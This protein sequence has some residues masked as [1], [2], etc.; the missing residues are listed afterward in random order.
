MS[1]RPFFNRKRGGFKE[2]VS[3]LKLG[4]ECTFFPGFHWEFA[5]SIG[6]CS[7][8]SVAVIATHQDGTEGIC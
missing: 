5:V 4:M 1:K 6:A 3:T 8:K 7:A 2:I